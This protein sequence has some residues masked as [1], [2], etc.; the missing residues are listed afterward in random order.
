LFG[1]FYTVTDTVA[2]GDAD[3]TGNFIGNNPVAKDSERGTITI[4]LPAKLKR[5][6]LETMLV[7]NADINGSN[8]TLSLKALDPYLHKLIARAHEFQA[9]FLCGRQ[10][11]TAM[12]EEAGV[13]F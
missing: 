10:T 11:I 2:E 9:I 7:I 3:T 12:A 6:G 1:D 4:S 8:D 13:K 5:T